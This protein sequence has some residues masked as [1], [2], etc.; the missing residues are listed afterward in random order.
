MNAIRM[1]H[2]L[3]GAVSE[4]ESVDDIILAVSEAV[5]EHWLEVRWY[6]VM[7]VMGEL[8]SESLFW[9]ACCA[10]SVWLCLARVFYANRL[11]P[12]LTQATSSRRFFFV[13]FILAAQ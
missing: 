1:I 3:G 6:Y 8:C 9:F 7:V 4:R 10:C 2:R 12:H 13:T 5:A 11:L